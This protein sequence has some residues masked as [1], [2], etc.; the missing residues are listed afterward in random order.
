M[1]ALVA[2][3]FI[4][5]ALTPALVRFLGP[6]VFLVVAAVPLVTFGW[7]VAM[8]PRVTGGEVLTQSIEWLPNLHFD[9]TLT[10]GVLPWLMTL[11]VS[12][13]GVLV[14]VYC[15]WYFADD[16]PSLGQFSGVFLAFAGAMLGLVL[17]DDLLLLYVFWELTTVFSYLLIGNDPGRRAS[18]LAAMQA[19]IVTTLGGLAMLVGVLM[20]GQ[21]SGTHLASELVADPP[22][23]AVATVAVVLVLVG[24]V[25]KSALVPFHFWLPGAMAAPTPVSAYLHA[26][27][28]VKA[29]VFLVALLAPGFADTPGWRPTVL[30]LGVLTMLLGG[31]RALRQYDVKLLLAYGTVSQL[32]FLLVVFSIGTRHAALAGLAML[33][34]HALFKATLFL[35]VGIIDHNAGTRDLRELSGVGARLPVVFAASVVAAAS[36]A[37]L[38]PM[39]GFVGKESVFGALLEDGNWLVVAGVVA[40]SALT[41]AYTLRFLWGAFASK[42]GVEETQ[43]VPV[44][45]GFAASPVILASLTLGLGFFGPT[46]THAFEPHVAQFPA[47]HHHAELALWHGLELPLLLSFV[48]I[49]LGLLLF[50]KRRL[51]AQ[52]QTLASS[53][54]SAERLYRAGMRAVDRSAVE[55][56]GFTQ[57]GSVAAYLAFILLVVLA[58]PGTVMLANLGTDLDVVL[59]DSPAQGVVGAL[60]VVAAIFTAR[61]RRRLRAVI[62]VGTTGYGTALLFLLHGAPDLALTQILVETTSLVVFV[63]V[64]RRLPEYFTDR[65]LSGR[66]WLRMLLGL[67]VGLA[68]AGF[69]LLAT[70]ARSA[71]PVSVDF[72]E[73]A[74]AYG[75]GHNIVSVILLDIRAWDTLG[76]ISVLVAAATG[77]ASLI[78]LDTRL[79]GIRRVRE[80]PYPETVEK[81]PT[82]AG[83]RVWLPGPRTLSPDRRS[84]IFEV[85]TRLMFHTMVVL[86]IYL[87]FAGHNHVGGGFAAGM[88]TGLALMVRYLA[89]GRYELDEAAPVDAGILMGTGLFL[90]AAAAL[91][92]IAFG[93]TVLQSAQVDFHLGPLGD[94]HLVTSVFFDL[95]VYL[96][97]VG[98][99]LDLLRTFGSRL[100]RQIL[101]AERES[102][103]VADR[104]TTVGV[105]Q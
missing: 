29:G 91:A 1:L 76:E 19:L 96:V 44:A 69:M 16:D 94:P 4:V 101:R 73:P 34:A 22:T 3:H 30:T 47:S 18:R 20:L 6:R 85:V 12:G 68:V 87:L 42:P 61:S 86:S 67:A 51:F 5:A 37:G 25:S 13:I 26:A 83:R 17:S 21:L 80:I 35:V 79:S 66:R 11:I 99:I 77:V 55:V 100:D 105:T 98:L 78:F 74:L 56:T 84:I 53:T 32:G 39:L 7:A 28:M 89:G 102:D 59:W 52:F 40:G 70:N 65:P 50:W 43:V 14:L 31:W 48:A 45:P 24:A 36:M 41:M 8:A 2:A 9:I 90:A 95:G 62:L 49:G 92:P 71:D 38:P 93:G 75:G 63:L 23:G 82:A 81:L 103:E 97:V 72:P 27:S 88:V 10:L 33:L 58:L 60:I 104:T 15:R 54:W 64:L 57:R 46:L